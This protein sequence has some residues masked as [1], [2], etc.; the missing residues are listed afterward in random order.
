MVLLVRNNRLSPLWTGVYDD[1]EGERECRDRSTNDLGMVDE[2]M[3]RRK[4]KK[5]SVGL[6]LN[7]GWMWDA[8]QGD[9]RW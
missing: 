2:R 7:S 6:A 9:C 3:S 8:C 4:L 1:G 5:Q